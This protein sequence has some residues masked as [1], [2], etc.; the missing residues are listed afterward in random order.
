MKKFKFYDQFLLE[1]FD[2]AESV[3]WK[4]KNGSFFGEFKGPNDLIYYIEIMSAED[5][6]MSEEFD[7][8]LAELTSSQEVF[9]NFLS[10]FYDVEFLDEQGDQKITGNA[11]KYT[12]KIFGT[13]INA[14]VS[15][16][17]EE[18]I[19]NFFFTAEDTP[20][21]KALYK[22]IVP[23]IATKL[24]YHQVNNGTFFFVS[25]QAL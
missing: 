3:T 8:A 25:K 10:N 9:N 19:S 11:G 24:G 21:R 6:G 16:V 20:S 23:I 2:S 7:S 13:I 14:I 18:D 4:S 22:K 12:T 17:K 5:S 15:K 1:V